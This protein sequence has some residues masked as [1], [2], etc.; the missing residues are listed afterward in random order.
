[1]V[2]KN[3]DV[4]LPDEKGRYDILKIHSRMMPLG[5]DVNFRR[6]AETTDGYTG[7]EL[8]RLCDEA[9]RKAL[10]R[11]LS[12]INLNKPEEEITKELGK[13]KVVMEDFIH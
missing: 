13:I 3:R 7:A 2:S 4:V 9:S 5:E 12:K 11:Q 6:L 1:M 10:N 8:K